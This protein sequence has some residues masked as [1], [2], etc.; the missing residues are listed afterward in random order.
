MVG[1]STILIGA[2]LAASA[3][4]GIAGL[5]ANM[6]AQ[7][8]AKLLQDQ[9]VQEWLKVNVPDPA[10]QKV[11]LQQFVQT[12]TLTPTL[13]Q[14]VKPVD[15]Q[16]TK[17][18]TDPALK[19]ARMKALSSLE[20]QGYGGEQVQDR[21]AREEGLIDSGSKS[22]GEQ[23]AVTSLMARRG[24]LGSGNE[25]AARL[26][27]AQADSDRNAK[28]ALDTEAQ[29]RQRALAATAS[30]GDLAGNIQNQSFNQQAQVAAAQ[31]AINRF[32]TQNQQSVQAQNAA[33]L[34]DASRYN[35]GLQQD[36]ANKN[37]ALSNEQQIYNKNVNQQN[38]ENQATKA[39][40]VSG[41]NNLAANQAIQFGQATGNTLA[42]VASGIGSLGLGGAK[43]YNSPS[44]SS[45]TT[46]AP[47]TN[48]SDYAGGDL[49][50]N[51]KYYA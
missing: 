26:S 19:G 46:A 43:L 14:A 30:A 20:Q 16:L 18:Q 40:G 25:L 2:A 3:G 33:A 9:S 5:A 24:Q 10:E 22:R 6:S 50:D 51:Q 7:D 35:L 28:I 36:I 49:E 27:N 13:Q 12:G 1:T 41:Q 17:I 39:A 38:F 15:T 34:T 42:G 23:Q 32:N 11:A 4:S 8:R 45:A 37:T 31:D 29:R 48:S 47:S 44:T 21:A